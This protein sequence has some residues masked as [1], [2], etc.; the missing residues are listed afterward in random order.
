VLDAG[1]TRSLTRFIALYDTRGETRSVQE[2]MGLGLLTFTLI[3]VLGT[4][5]AGK[6]SAGISQ[7][8]IATK[9]GLIVA[10]PALVVHGFLS[11]R[12]QK[13]LALLDRYALE[14]ATACEEGQR[15]E[16]PEEATRP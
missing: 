13:H 16:R 6:L 12:I 11:H 4:G 5:S 14:I 2:C 9:F 1:I 15:S 8:L 3:T 10:I 7:A